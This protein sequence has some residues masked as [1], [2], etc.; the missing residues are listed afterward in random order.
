MVRMAIIHVEHV[1][2]PVIY[3]CEGKRAPKSF[4]CLLT[5]ITTL[6]VVPAR[7]LGMASDLVTDE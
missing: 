6:L 3:L 1:F 2:H 7:K 5:E 4:E